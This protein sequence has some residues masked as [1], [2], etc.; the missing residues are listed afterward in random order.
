MTQT[1]ELWK[2]NKPAYGLVESGRLWQ[3]TIEPW[4]L[5]EFNAETVPGLPQLFFKRN[6]N[7]QPD[8]IIAKVAEDILL[9]GTVAELN[10]FRHTYR[11]IDGKTQA[12]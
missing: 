2:L 10:K 3:L 9:A 7:N 8:S 6:L 11:N 4:M 1:G 5:D 12:E